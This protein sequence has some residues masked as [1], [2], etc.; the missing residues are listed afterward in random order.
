MTLSKH[1][2]YADKDL[3]VANLQGL[4]RANP[5]LSLIESEK[6]VFRKPS[7]DKVA[8]ISGGG[9]GHEPLHGG[10]VGSNLLDAAVSGSIFASPAT[11]QIM[12]AIKS[13]ATKEHGVVLVVKN[14]TGDVL[15]FGLVAE[16]AKAEGYNAE[17]LMVTDDVAVGRDQNAMV[18]RRGLA[19]TAL[20]HKV[21]GGASAQGHKLSDVVRL[22]ELVN[23]NLATLGAS[24]D[25][26]SVPGR[27]ADEQA[28]FTGANE[29]EV[30]LGI[31]NEPGAKVSP[32][33]E[34]SELVKDMYAKLTSPDDKQRH[35]VDFDTANDDYVVLVNNIGGTSTFEMNIIVEHAVRGLPFKKRPS[36][37]YV[38][39]FVTS[40]NSPGFSITL[41]RLPSSEKDQLLKLL[42]L[43][44]DA[45]GWRPATYQ[46]WNDRD[47]Q[48]VPSP[49]DKVDV[50]TSELRF[51]G[52]VFSER[53]R[54]GLEEVIKQEPKITHYDTV[55][56]DGDCG[57][58]LKA[59]AEAILKANPVS[60]DPVET[61]NRITDIV[62]ETMGGTSGGLYSIYLTALSKHLKGTSGEQVAEAMK[63]A[64]DDGL[65]KYTRARKGGRTLVDTL[66]PF[67][68]TFASTKD[69]KKAV[70]AATKGC[71]STKTLEAKFGRASYVDE[72]EFKQEGG[73]PDPGAVGLL[74]IIKGFTS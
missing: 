41:L 5:S 58:T 55:V 52:K 7:A 21:V 6:V 63:G 19:G 26:T 65:F 16:R 72:S 59:G 32:I 57:E 25:R 45:P 71:E 56:G 74:A 15:H 46:G 29:A 53:L 67:V 13:V 17:L 38:S 47:S 69:L 73:I 42:D 20:V 12:A 28:E 44:T 18:G 61:L 14:Y 4:V 62:E 43:P 22:G 48:S 31:H 3:V 40:L 9:A 30:G 33:P 1:W 70:E 34:I 37:V 68:E 11:R 39:D 10:Y 50:P 66:Q 51:D 2:N 35:Y 60:D 24:L 49:M 8:I 36:R 27:A 54:K 64:L 23:E